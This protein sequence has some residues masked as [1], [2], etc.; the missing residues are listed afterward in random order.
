MVGD[1]ESIGMWG[2]TRKLLLLPAEE[3][4]DVADTVH[5]AVHVLVLQDV[6]DL[7]RDHPVHPLLPVTPSHHPHALPHPPNLG[8]LW[9]M[10]LLLVMGIAS[11]LPRHL[12]PPAREE[13]TIKTYHLLLI[14][15]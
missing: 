10:V 5:H 3:A 2:W 1:S 14:V 13:W 9:P 8:L 6:H 4:L 12:E 11:A 15:T 7:P